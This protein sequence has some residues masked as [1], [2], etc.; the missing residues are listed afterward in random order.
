KV[1]KHRPDR[2]R[3]TDKLLKSSQHQLG[4]I[5]INLADL[6][7]LIP[8]SAC[9]G[10]PSFEGSTLTLEPLAPARSAGARRFL[11][12][13]VFLTIAHPGRVS[14]VAQVTTYLFPSRASRLAPKRL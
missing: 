4:G 12:A 10:G 14:V 13:A 9:L 1:G 6:R 7:F 3:A 5:D 11:K 8:S 2:G